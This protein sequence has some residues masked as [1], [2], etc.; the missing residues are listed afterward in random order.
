MKFIQKKSK[1]LILLPSIGLV[2]MACNAQAGER[3]TATGGVTQIEGASGGGLVPWA[4]I[5]GYDTQ[6]Q[7]GGSTYLTKLRTNGGFELN[8]AGFAIGIENRVEFS[9]SQQRFGLSNTIPNT[10]IRMDTLGAK[11]KLLGDAVYDQDT[12]IPQLALGLQFK[13]NEDF[14]NVPRA[15]NARSA[16]GTDL[17][18]T[19]TKLYLA[20]LAGRNVLLNATLRATKANQFGIL[21]FGGDNHDQYQIQPELTAALMLTDQLILGAEYRAKPNN[22]KAFKEEDAKDVF[23]TWFPVKQLSLT[24]AWVDLG[25]IANKTDQRGWYLSGQ[26]LY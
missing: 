8:T 5:A 19:A 20:G 17:Y 26:V 22:L 10:T 2:A 23:L 1:L 13:H 14:S 3:L 15:I 24:A 7:I 16:N 9:L 21:G 6:D 12:W 4:L 11:I 18:L 25:N